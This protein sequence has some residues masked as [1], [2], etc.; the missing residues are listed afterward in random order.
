MPSRTPRYPRDQ[1]HSKTYTKPVLSI[2][3]DHS[4]LSRCALLNLVNAQLLS[5]AF[6][7]LTAPPSRWQEV[8][9]VAGVAEGRSG[10]ALGLFRTSRDVSSAC[11]RGFGFRIH[12]GG[13]ELEGR[14]SGARGFGGGMFC[15]LWWVASFLRVGKPRRPSGNRMRAMTTG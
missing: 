4:S 2:V 14:G 5:R 6:M 3:S 11:G 13:L 15:L 7:M 10:A 8:S 1:S 12:D 9:V